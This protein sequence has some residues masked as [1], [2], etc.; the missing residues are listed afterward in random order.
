MDMNFQGFA[1][2]YVQAAYTQ[3]SCDSSNI[4]INP[5][6]PWSNHQI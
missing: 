6:P 4:I 5:P 3:C 1:I 2:L